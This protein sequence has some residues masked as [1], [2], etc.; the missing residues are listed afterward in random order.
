M[1]K[2]YQA[3]P[4]Q[5]YQFSWCLCGNSIDII[6]TVLNE[7][8]DEAVIYPGAVQSLMLP[9]WLEITIPAQVVAAAPEKGTCL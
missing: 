1:I 9:L 4:Q 6:G 7:I 8:L 2:H 5:R 3:N